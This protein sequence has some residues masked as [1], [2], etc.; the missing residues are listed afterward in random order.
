MMSQLQP[1]LSSHY[2]GTYG[3][4]CR[5]YGDTPVETLRKI[6]GKEFAPGLLDDSKLSDILHRLDELSLGMLIRDHY[7]RKLEG[8]IKKSFIA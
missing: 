6:Y 1:A 4:I 7:Q 5:S 8:Q 3:K 2:R